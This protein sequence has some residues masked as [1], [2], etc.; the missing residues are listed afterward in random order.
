VDKATAPVLVVIA[1]K[2]VRQLVGWIC[3][4]L[5]LRYIAVASWRRA[6]AD[7][8]GRP[9]LAVVDLDDVGAQRAGLVGLLR[10]GWGAAVPFIGLSYKIESV[11][12]PEAA[13]ILRKPINVGL[14]MGAIGRAAG[15]G[16]R[17]ERD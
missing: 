3:D 11:D 16:D 5:D 4:E 14:L 13:D 10:A 12:V 9:S 8:D 15:D 2:D 7:L 17:G 6:V 1:D